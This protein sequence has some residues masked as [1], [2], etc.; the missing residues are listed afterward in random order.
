MSSNSMIDQ[1]NSRENFNN[2]NSL[3]HK[4][5]S[6]TSNN[7]EYK[8]KLLE[9]VENAN[10]NSDSSFLDT[11]EKLRLEQRVQLAQV[12]RDYYN[13]MPTSSID[14]PNYTQEKQ[15]QK[16]HE[17]IVTK[18]PPLPKSSKQLPSPVFLTEERAQHHMHQR[19]MSANII[20]RHD[21]EIAFCPHRTSTSNTTKTVHDLTTN[22]IKHQIQSLWNEFELDDYL[23]QKKT[24]RLP[25]AASW[26][27]RI[28]IPEPFALTNSMNMDNIHRTKCMHEIEA[29][30]LRKEVDEELN[31]RRSVK[32]NTV[33]AHVR[34]PL[35]EQLQEEQRTRR[36]QVH[37]M[38]RDYL[39]SIS[40]P[41]SFDA[42]EKAKTILRRHSY[43]A[44]DIIQSGF[45]FKAKP[46]P[47]FYYHTHHDNEQIK[48]QSL[49][50][51]VRRDKRAKELLQQS[52]LPF[53]NQKPKRTN[54]SMS[55]N[56]LARLGYE[57]YSFKPKTNG[58]YVPNYDKIHSKFLRNM[59]QKKRTRSPTKCKP[60]LL[61][62]NL[63][64]SKKD[65]I[66]DDI[67]KDEK[68]QH[69]RTFQIKGKPMPTK[70][71]SLTN[72]SASFQQS[73]AIPTKTT[74]AQRLREAV[75]K[76][77][78]REE[79][80]KNHF[81]ETFQRSKSAKERKVREKIR[82]KAKLQDQ[83]VVLKAK[84]DERSRQ[85]RQDMRKSEDDY[86]KKLDEMN[87][88]LR[89][90]PLLL[91]Q[92]SKQKAVRELERKIKYAMSLA[93]VTEQ[94]LI[95]QQFNSQNAKLTTTTTVSSS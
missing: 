46:L 91:E 47:H 54:R 38:T 93:N 64:P 89:Q 20:Q 48:E 21:D 73:E 23:E 15:V 14:M 35:Y 85:M 5:H 81:D 78:R 4:I 27:G 71:A 90:R 65:K 22:H 49:Y 72:L 45:Q 51:S 30:K 77:K 56:D 7:D 37:Q 9:K 29:A 79:N 69:S 76:K 3:S 33:P 10:Q 44:G 16:K 17:T 67:Q 55:V 6:N 11:L 34:M 26:A 2:L 60:F 92:D 24:R 58:Y 31:L 43:S 42:R 13:Q 95:G 36:E 50:R 84:R 1:Y 74:E 82:E 32:A 86:A 83:A 25:T 40:K 62:T 28:T 8:Q 75:G 41:F 59:E 70:S 80:L 39:S 88:R 53:S 12:E 19:S 94:D 18:K 68:I 61:Y 66:L 87:E 52:R 57:E 63:I